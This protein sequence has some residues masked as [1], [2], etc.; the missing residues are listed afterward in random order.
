MKARKSKIR[1]KFIVQIDL[2]LVA[3]KVRLPLLKPRA[4]IILQKTK[5]FAT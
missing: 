4:G 1:K 3:K 5:V 2:D